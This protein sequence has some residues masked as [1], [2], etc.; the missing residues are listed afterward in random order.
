MNQIAKDIVGD[1]K[2]KDFIGNN[3]GLTLE[4]LKELRNVLNGN[5]LDLYDLHQ[6]S[7]IFEKHPDL[8]IAFTRKLIE[9]I[10]GKPLMDKY[11]K[12]ID[13]LD[14][15]PNINHKMIKEIF[16][17][18]KEEPNFDKLEKCGELLK[19][20]PEM[21]SNMLLEEFK[22]Y[23]REEQSKSSEDKTGENMGENSDNSKDSN[24]VKTSEK[25]V[26]E[27]NK[28]MDD[29]LKWSAEKSI[30]TKLKEIKDFIEKKLSKKFN[31]TIQLSEQAVKT[32]VGI[33]NLIKKFWK[34]TYKQLKTHIKTLSDMIKDNKIVRFLLEWWFCGRVKRNET[35]KE[36]LNNKEQ[37]TTEK[38]KIL[39]EEDIIFEKQEVKAEKSDK[40][41]SFE[42]NNIEGFKEMFEKYRLN[43]EKIPV[44]NFEGM[45]IVKSDLMKI[46]QE[47]WYVAK[48]Q[49]KIGKETVYLSDVFNKWKDYLVG[50]TADWEIRLFY[51]S[52]SEGLRRS[53]DWIRSDWA[54]SKWE[55]IENYSYETTTQVEHSIGEF[56]DS[57]PQRKSWID[58][59]D[60]FTV[61]AN[62]YGHIP[63]ILRPSLQTGVQVEK[64]GKF[65]HNNAVKYYQYKSVNAVQEFYRNLKTDI[66]LSWISET[67]SF[68]HPG[69]WE[70]HVDIIKAK[71]KDG[72]D[73][74]LHFW[75]AVN[76]N[77]NSVFIIRWD[78]L[79]WD[80]NSFG[81]KSKQLNLWPLWAKPIDYTSQVPIDWMSN[82]FKRYGE[83]YVDI[84]ALYQEMPLIKS[85]KEMIKKAE[86]KSETKKQK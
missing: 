56:F 78:Y 80:V 21:D 37:R 52:E 46:L 45:E 62:K 77:P 39:K 68:Q 36:D 48:H 15:Y 43:S 53:C 76:D 59:Q 38:E 61:I 2:V 44:G 47:N 31:K 35:K 73:I 22:K 32:L 66:T 70:I 4:K 3:K 16:E 24:D 55:R 75:H 14:R 34:L 18:T 8:D 84:R 57:L 19:N 83:D 40:K 85:Y 41:I 25:E 86:N 72:T 12:Y 65:E 10:E 71:L 49:I 67:Y 33:R 74:K 1:F 79:E 5:K 26:Q 17:L 42:K 58:S 63:N 6:Y 82:N 60:P 54:L 64:I 30:E 29:I 20:H 11:E 81:I 27:N 23:K 50:Y 7:T 51:K 9:K 28:Q 69:L 13:F